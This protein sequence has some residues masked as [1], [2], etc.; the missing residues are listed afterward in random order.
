MVKKKKFRSMMKMTDI[1]N[2]AVKADK[3]V[4]VFPSEHENHGDIG[5]LTISSSSGDKHDLAFFQIHVPTWELLAQRQFEFSFFIW[6]TENIFLY[7]IEKDFSELP[8]I[9]ENESLI[10][11]HEA[12]TQLLTTKNTTWH[13]LTLR[14][15]LEQPGAEDGYLECRFVEYRK[16]EN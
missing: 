2:T 11:R 1:L 13:V 10:Q 4:Y 7:F 6:L 16:Y 14:L 3:F 9:P 12:F 5:S 8:A 15:Q